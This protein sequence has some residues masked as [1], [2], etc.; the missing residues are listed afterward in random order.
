MFALSEKLKMLQTS[1]TFNSK[2]Q[3]DPNMSNLKKKYV[4]GVDLG[5]S[6]LK[7]ALIDVEGNIISSYTYPTNPEKGFQSVISD[8]VSCVEKCLK[9][10]KYKA[11]ALGIGIAGQIDFSG[12]IQSAPNLNWRDVPLKARL[13]QELELQV[14]VT[15]DVRAATYGEWW[16]GSGK[17]FKDL[18]VI[19]VGTGIG[20]GV[21]TGGKVLVGCSNTG[22]ELG[23]LTIVSGGRRC[24]CPNNGCLEAYAGGWAIAERGQERI[25]ANPKAGQHILSLAG[26]IEEIT[27]ATISQA[28]YNGDPLARQLVEETGHYLAAGAVGIINSFNPCLLVFGGGVIEG[29]P[30]IIKMVSDHVKVKAL[31]PSSE[32]LKIVKATLG[33]EAGVVGAAALALKMVKGSGERYEP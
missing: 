6:K 2:L 21:V 29:L 23:H 28:F 20:G 8:I 9:H 31:K 26:S 3:G 10:G 15:N 18:V 5:G 17:G 11:E 4:L 22:G 25:R 7:T 33:G 30:V 32:R 16:F 12:N 24:H 13:K 27:A 1:S 19:F 14:A